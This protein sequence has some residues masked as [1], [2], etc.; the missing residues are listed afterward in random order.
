MATVTADLLALEMRTAADLPKVV[1]ESRQGVSADEL[2]HTQQTCRV[3]SA[4]RF[5][6]QFLARFELCSV[7]AG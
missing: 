3:E 4:A 5:L 6:A 2:A 7:H 1:P